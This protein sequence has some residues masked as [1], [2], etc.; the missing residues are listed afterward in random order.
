MSDFKFLPDGKRL[1]HLKFEAKRLS[2]RD[3]IK[4]TEALNLLAKQRY[5][6]SFNKLSDAIE[7]ASPF[8]T[9]G[10][11]VL[12]FHVDD[13]PRCVVVDSSGFHVN[14]ETTVKFHPSIETF[15]AKSLRI[16]DLNPV[17]SNDQISG[18]E[19][20]AALEHD[21]KYKIMVSGNKI[22]VMIDDYVMKTI[23]DTQFT[24]P[25]CS[26]QFAGLKARDFNPVIH[27][28][29]KVKLMDIPL[30]KEIISTNINYSKAYWALE[31][32]SERESIDLFEATGL[33]LPK[34][35]VNASL[36]KD[37][38]DQ[39]IKQITYKVS[40]SLDCYCFEDIGDSNKSMSMFA[41]SE[42]EAVSEFADYFGTQ[43]YNNSEALNPNNIVVYKK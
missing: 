38:L 25:L 30:A 5:G 43:L 34:N 3:S 26:H 7:E 40:N 9:G 35:M 24:F 20:E 13:T 17:V 14:F 32:D 41:L 36:S 6:K 29:D 23:S 19:V 2:K 37:C 21:D 39:L 1:S 10:N 8:W 12:P 28:N 42:Q 11:L 15:K 22:L 18:W 31:S 27:Q 33:N 4:R 16:S